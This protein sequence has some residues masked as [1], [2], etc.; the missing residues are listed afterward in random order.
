L[1]AA[2]L[3]AAAGSSALALANAPVGPE[4]YTAG[5]GK[6]REL[7]RGEPVLLLAPAGQL[8]DRHGAEFYGWELRGARPICVA[9]A[10]DGDV[11]FGAPAPA[12]IRYVITL[13]GKREPPFDDVNE[14]SR[15]RRVALWEVEGFEPGAPPVPIDAAVP[16]SCELGLEG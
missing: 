6:L 3:L 15:R 12:G 8:S 9:P 10:P 13:G 11:G 2:F 4:R 16:T 14:I 5:I 7:L 1:A